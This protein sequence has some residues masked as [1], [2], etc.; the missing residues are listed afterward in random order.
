MVLVPMTVAPV[1]W[2]DA[3]LDRL[4]A[5]VDAQTA[6]EVERTVQE[7]REAGLPARVLIS[8]ALEGAGKGAPGPRIVSTVKQY[9]MALAGAR[10]ALGGSAA[11][12]EIVAGAGALMVG[13]PPDSLARL[14]ASRPGQT[15]VVPLVVLADLVAR[16]VPAP[17]ASGTILAAT[18]AGAR[19]AELLALREG[20]EQDIRAGVT[21][22]HAATLRARGWT[23]GTPAR[24]PRRGTGSRP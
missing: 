13:V 2:A 18:R 16:K 3:D 19:D 5:R 22:L 1:A 17:A 11:E 12:T 24:P 14:R 6:A 21:P 20:V 10:D 23:P 4:R 7:A 9:G 8:K 15:L